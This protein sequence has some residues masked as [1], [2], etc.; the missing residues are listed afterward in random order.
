MEYFPKELILEIIDKITDYNDIYNFLYAYTNVVFSNVRKDNKLF[1]IL[2]RQ[3]FPSLFNDVK[4]LINNNKYFKWPD[5]Y[6]RLTAYYH[7]D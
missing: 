1:E 4:I 7:L 3:R 5:V 2:I 6:T